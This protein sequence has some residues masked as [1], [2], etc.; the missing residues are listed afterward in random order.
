MGKATLFDSL[1]RQLVLREGERWQ[2]DRQFET[3]NCYLSVELDEFDAA[4][5]RFA[6]L[7]NQ[8]FVDIPHRPR[9]ADDPVYTDR[10]LAAHHVVH[11]W[12]T[13]A[14]AATQRGPVNDQT[15][16]AQLPYGV[17]DRSKRNR[18]SATQSSRMLLTV[19]QPC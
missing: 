1:M 16:R 6:S 7:F 4:R 11:R 15:D 12:H 2:F 14:G 9:R 5:R 18:M 13:V 10:V 19:V 17:R 3:T 8:H